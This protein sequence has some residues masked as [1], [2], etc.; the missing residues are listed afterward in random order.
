VT[1]NGVPPPFHRSR[2]HESWV[3]CQPGMAAGPVKVIVSVN[4]A[5]SIALVVSAK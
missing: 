4:R 1:M 3:L 5:S 2:Q